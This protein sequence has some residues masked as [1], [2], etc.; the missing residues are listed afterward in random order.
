MAESLNVSRDQGDRGTSYE[1]N[2]GRKLR[3]E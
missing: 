2:E 3:N 1:I